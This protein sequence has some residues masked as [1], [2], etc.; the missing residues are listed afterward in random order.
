MPL[1]HAGETWSWPV[2]D[3]PPTGRHAIVVGGSI[4]GLATA[5]MLR[6]IGWQVTVCERS[7]AEL[8]GRGA[9]IFATHPE[10][11]EALS[12][13]G[14]DTGG[15]GVLSHGR[16]VLDR[17]GGVV[18]RRGMVQ[19]VTSWDRLQGVLADA[20]G[21]EVV[22]YGHE[23]TGLDSDGNGVAAE[24]SNGRRL[25]ADVLV[26]C[27]G[28]LSSVRTLTGFEAVPEYSGYFLWR[29]A[30]DEL[31]L[32]DHTRSSIFDTYS[33]YVGTHLQ[34]LGYPIPGGRHGLDPGSRRYNFAWFRLAD[35]DQLGEM[36]VDKA[37]VH[38]EFS[39]PP[40]HVRRDLIDG[41]RADAGEL[42]PPHV[43]CVDQIDQPFFTPIYDVMPDRMSSGRVAFV[44]DAA[45]TVRPHAG[46]GA[47]KAASEALA[48]AE[49]LGEVDEVG[50]AL[51]LY[52]RRRLPVAR[53][54]VAHGR[55]LGAQLGS[56]LE[57]AE[58][59]AMHRTLQ[60]PQELMGRIAVPNF[61][62]RV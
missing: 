32:S 2:R 51:A 56:R 45:A 27:D 19:L 53:K 40:P 30:P 20:A 48:L 59:V 10:L 8:T 29:G 6:R 13:C 26:G 17:A 7:N 47:S 52:E 49:C 3:L 44:G 38:H 25:R 36:L 42:L 41:M 60:D 22:Q 43:D 5:A 1:T 34:A 39:V 14:A 4:A 21:R 12:R 54:A 18:A 50:E 37:G 15:L 61:L 55:L 62:A 23:L 11:L 16:V 9:G 58:E 24:F 28:W 31:R 33:F 46:F 35:A 57:T